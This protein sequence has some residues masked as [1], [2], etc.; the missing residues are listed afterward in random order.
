MATVQISA[1]IAAA[2]VI[3]ILQIGRRKDVYR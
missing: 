3:N 2:L 1:R